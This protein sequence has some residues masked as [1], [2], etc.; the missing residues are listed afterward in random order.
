MIKILKQFTI[1]IHYIE[2][3]VSPLGVSCDTNFDGNYGS[4]SP[5]DNEQEIIESIVRFLKYDGYGEI[6]KPIKEKDIEFVNKTDLKITLP[7][8]FAKIN[9]ERQMTL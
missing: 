9:G 3:G 6:R 2:N 8:L 7:I 5:C 1:D 4:S